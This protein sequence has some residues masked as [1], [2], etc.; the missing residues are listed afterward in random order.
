MASS[1]ENK[2]TRLA[3]EGGVPV[4]RTPFPRWP[5]FADDDIDAV[6]TVLRSGRVNYWTGDQCRQFEAEFARFAKCQHAIAVANGTVALELALVALG[7]GPGDEVIVPCRSFV[8]S[9]SCAAVRGANVVFADVDPDSQ[10]ITAET[11]KPV[12]T[13]RTKAV[14]AVHLAGWP[15]DMEPILALAQQRGFAVIED[16]AQAHGAEY[17]G[18]PVGSWGHVAAFSFCQDK[19]MSTGGEGGMLTTNDDK[20]YRRAWEYKDHGKSLEAVSQPG[21]PGRFRWLHETIGTNWRMTEMQAA[22]GRVALGKLAGW[23]NRRREN[24][25]RLTA[26]LAH[27]PAIRIPSPPEHSHPA[28]YKQ[29]FFVRPERLRP[30]WSRDKIVDALLAEG[31]P[32]G[33]GICPE[34]YLEGAFRN[35]PARPTWRF[36]NAK[37]LGE[38]SVMLPV[39]PTLEATDIDDMIAAVSKVIHDAELSDTQVFPSST[40]RA[41][42]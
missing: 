35:S 11:I 24:A 30:G 20:I 41:A 5:V 34:I 4:R 26:G 3:L 37:R 8:A 42:G 22:L 21:S 12:C 29:Y 14:I 2:D 1:T 15:C 25:A 32:C 36:A 28:P 16:C 27:L 13:R 40:W 23:V 33:T 38:T 6:T 17:H 10:N 31:I 18:Q 7:I 39:H 19:I 9:A